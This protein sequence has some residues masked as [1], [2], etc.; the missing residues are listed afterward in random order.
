[1][2]TSS[3]TSDT[4]FSEYVSEMKARNIPLYLPSINKSERNF[5]IYNDGLVYPLGEIRGVNYLLVDKIIEETLNMSMKDVH[6]LVK[7]KFNV[8]Y[9]LKRIGKLTK[10]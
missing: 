5:I 6:I 9:S 10:N 2:M 3:S 8:D 1:M 4:K 7:E